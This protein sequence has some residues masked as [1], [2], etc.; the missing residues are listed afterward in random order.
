MTTTADNHTSTAQ[1]TS[2]CSHAH[3]H[4]FARRRVPANIE[5]TDSAFVLSL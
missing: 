4:P 1:P 2:R 3:S 5:E